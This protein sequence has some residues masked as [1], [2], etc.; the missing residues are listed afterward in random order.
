M[1]E[2]FPMPTHDDTGM[3]SLSVV[4]MAYEMRT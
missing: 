2:S 4:V 3:V 1:V